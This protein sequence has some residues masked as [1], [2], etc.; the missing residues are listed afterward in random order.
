MAGYRKLPEDYR[1]DAL[2]VEASRRAKK[3][4]RRHSYGML[5]ADTTPEERSEIADRYARN[6]KGSQEK[7][8][9]KM[10]I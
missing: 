7:W 4:G 10:L 6:R 9:Y 3:L 1:V 2:A 8:K 5:V